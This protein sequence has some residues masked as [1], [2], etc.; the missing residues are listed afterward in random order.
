MSEYGTFDRS[1]MLSHHHE[2]A[3]GVVLEAVKTVIEVHRHLLHNLVRAQEAFDEHRRGSHADF[4]IYRQAGRP[5]G[6]S[7]TCPAPEER[8]SNRYEHDGA[9]GWARR[10]DGTQREEAARG[11]RHAPTSTPPSTRPSTGPT[12]GLD[13]KW[14][15][16]GLRDAAPQLGSTASPARRPRPPTPRSCAW[17]T[18]W[19]S[20]RKEMDKACEA[21]SQAADGVLGRRA[22]ASRTSRSVPPSADPGSF[23]YDPNSAKDL[24]EQQARP[25]R[26]GRPAYNAGAAAREK[27]FGDALAA[28]DSS[29]LPVAKTLAEVHGMEP[30]AE[31]GG[32]PGGGASGGWRRRLPAG[33]TRAAVSCWVPNYD[34]PA[35]ARR[36]PR[37]RRLRRRRLRRLRR[38]RHR[39]ASAATPA[40]VADDDR[41][42]RRRPAG[43][44]ARTRT[45]RS[46]GRRWATHRCRPPAPGTPLPGGAPVPPAR[47]RTARSTPV[48]CSAA[49]WW[50]GMTGAGWPAPSRARSASACTRAVGAQR[51]RAPRRERVRPGPWAVV[52]PA[53]RSGRPRAAGSA[54][55]RGAAGRGGTE[56]AGAGG[57][58]GRGGARAGSRAGRSRRRR[59]RRQAYQGRGGEAPRPPRLDRRDQRLDRRRRSR[60]RR[61]RLT[62]GPSRRHRPG[63]ARARAVAFAPDVHRALTATS[64]E[65]MVSMSQAPTSASGPSSL[66]RVTVASGSRRVD[67]VLPGAV[68]V[69]ELVPELARS[70]G[71]LDGAT[72]YGGYH[73][74][75]AEGRALGRRRRP[76]H[77]G[78]RGR[79][80]DHRVRRG[81]RPGPARLRRRGRGDDRRRRARPQ[82]LAAGLGAAYRPL[83]RGPAAR[84]RS[85]RP[86]DPGQPARRRSRRRWSPPAWSPARSSSR[87]RSTSPRPP[88]PWPGWARLRRRRRADA[89]AGGRPRSPSRVVYAATGVDHRRARLPGRARRGPHPDDPAGRGRG[90][91]PGDRA[92]A[93]APSTFGYAEVLTTTLVLVVDRRQRLPVDGARGDRDARRPA[94]QRRRHHRRPRRDRRRPGGRRRA[95]PPTRSSWR[96]PRPSACCWC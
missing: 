30:P 22:G 31:P 68:P 12:S 41:A 9:D 14:V 74:V 36:R 90:G 64:R 86:A 53:P 3:H 72:V 71:L 69:A 81:R 4:V 44:P 26:Q 39:P 76:D 50:R 27:A 87:A 70:V 21:L 67:L 15:M 43:R 88:S 51:P 65:W 80:A 2:L 46:P 59:S 47:P 91:V 61:D 94:L 29:Y 16:E 10:R 52:R 17:P 63:R 85:G 62:R 57:S 96:S 28:V 56:A 49:A 13:V 25:Q 24:E 37:R 60:A 6:R 95:A 8:R 83:R 23:S 40:D 19:T 1:P 11:H 54:G 84:P 58:P 55:G 42:A 75:T 35:M 18:R 66:V 5:H 34:P 77:P 32:T 20:S 93:A 73:L 45:S 79:R 82:A 89:R 7:R 33:G 48:P 78:R 92:A 38:P